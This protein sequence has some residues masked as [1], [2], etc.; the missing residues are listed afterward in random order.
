L[1]PEADTAAMTAWRQGKLIFHDERLEEAVRRINRHS[2]EQV[3]IEDA[4]LA[5]RRISGVF[6]AD[7]ALA[8]SQAVE[9]SMAV[10]VDRSRPQ[11]I[12]LQSR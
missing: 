11:T 1:T 10:T 5:S 4:A 9:A 3:E 8:F 7:D 2:R 6:D 12:R